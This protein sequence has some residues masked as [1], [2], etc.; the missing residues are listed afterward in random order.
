MA[1][2]Q[3]E[4]PGTRRDDEPEHVVIAAIEELC[5]ALHKL[6]AKRMKLAEQEEQKQLELNAALTEHKLTLY[7]Y[8]DDEGVAREAY[9]TDPRVKIRK[10]KAAGDDE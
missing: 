5:D 8:T 6:R 3:T 9:F 2:K 10:V 7:P 1:K 4:L